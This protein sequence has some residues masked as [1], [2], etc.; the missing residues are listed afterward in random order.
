MVS[1]IYRNTWVLTWAAVGAFCELD[2]RSFI[3]R[4]GATHQMKEGTVK[5]CVVCCNND[6][7]AHLVAL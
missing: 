6:P 4:S 3:L 2:W 7:P 5:V 1:L